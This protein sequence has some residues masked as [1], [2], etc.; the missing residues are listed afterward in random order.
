MTQ[1]ETGTS[2]AVDGWSPP[3]AQD[4]KRILDSTRSIAIVGASSNP[5]RA[6]NFVITYLKSSVC[7]FDLYPV[8]PRE[9]EILGLRCYPSLAE[10]PIVPDLVSVF[11]RAE[12]CPAIAEEVVAVGAK[13]LWLQLGIW[14]DE[15]A[16][17]AVGG[18]LDVAMDRCVKIEHARFAG[19]LHLA[20]FNT[21]V[22]DSRR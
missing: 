8:N 13:T 12:D 15:A 16:R 14:S 9:T 21:G 20:G 7:D 18:G 22:I 4:R 6:S 11:R 19:G 1:T 3:S 5:A 17:I 10:L 2:T